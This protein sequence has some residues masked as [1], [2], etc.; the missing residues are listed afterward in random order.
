MNRFFALF[1]IFFFF[2]VQ[3]KAQDSTTVETSS[4]SQ[5]FALW[6][7]TGI[8]VPLAIA[9][10]VISVLPPSVGIV[11][12]DGVIYGSLNFETG[13]GFGKKRLTG[14]FLHF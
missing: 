12:K 8:I 2:V 14:V 6:T 10:V 1:V 4:T 3:T 9:G 11:S 7:M 5:S 13:Y